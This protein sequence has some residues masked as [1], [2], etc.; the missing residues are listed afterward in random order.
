MIDTHCHIDLYPNPSEIA[1]GAD[2]SGVLT[3]IVTNLPSA[4][5]RAWPYVREMKKLRLALGLHPLVALQHGAERGRFVELVDRTSY[6][7]EIGL[8]FSREGVATKEIQMESFRFVLKALRGKPKFITLHSRQ[9]ESAVLDILEEEDRSPVVFHWYTGPLSSMMRALD[10]GHYFSINP[11]MVKSQKGRKII[12]SLP[13]D[14][15]LTES[16]GPFVRVGGM[17]A[18]PSDVA[19]VEDHLASV[20]LMDRAE[21]SRL[22]RG[23]FLN[24]LA[25]VL[26]GY[27]RLTGR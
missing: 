10:K 26:A 27:T 4:F 23:N 5:E 24:L 13:L 22:I 14:R 2:R 21:V 6:I 17:S 9:A 20:W 1:A 12:E 7:G 18:V 11:A 15:V 3:V 25:P 16:D 8:D 19:C